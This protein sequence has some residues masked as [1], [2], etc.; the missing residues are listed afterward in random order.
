MPLP[1][2]SLQLR[3]ITWDCTQTELVRSL[4]G[5]KGDHCWRYNFDLQI[6]GT[7]HRPHFPNLKDYETHLFTV[8]YLSLILSC[9]QVL[10]RI[11]ICFAYSY[12]ED[13]CKWKLLKLIHGLK[14]ECVFV[15]FVRKIANISI[16]IMTQIPFPINSSKWKLYTVSFDGIWNRAPLA[17]LT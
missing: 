6:F 7:R 8:Y 5:I 13:N 2:Q 16:F 12:K 15:I 11:R 9:V 17:L 1:S 14:L 4:A 10:H 3:I